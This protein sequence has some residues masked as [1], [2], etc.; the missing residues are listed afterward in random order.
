MSGPPLVV[1]PTNKTPGLFLRVNLLYGV[2]SPGSA[3][4]RCLIVGP[5]NSAG[6]AQTPDTEVRTIS[7]MA[8]IEAAAGVGSLPALAYKAALQRDPTIKCDLI[9]PTESNGGAATGTITPSGTISTDGTIR[10]VISGRVIDVPWLV[11][12]AADAW[13]TKAIAYINKRTAELFVTASSGGVGVVT[14]TAKGKGPAG[15]DVTLRAKIIEGCTSG[16]VAVSGAKLTGGTTEPVFTTALAT[17]AGTEYDYIAL[18]ASNA[19]VNAAS[20][21]NSDNLQTHIDAYNIG[22]DAHLQQGVLGTTTSVSSA[23]TGAIGLNSEVMETMLGIGVESLPCEVAGAEMGDRSYARKLRGNA[24]RIGT[25]MSNALLPSAD[26][27]GD[28][29]TAAEAIDALDNGVSLLH[30][31]ANGVIRVMR[32]ITTHSVDAN[33]NPD[34]R[35]LDCNEVDAMY[36]YAKDLRAALPQEFHQ[37][38]VAADREEGDEEL[39]EGVVECRDIKAF[40]ISRTMGYWVPKGYINGVEFQAAADAGQV[41]VQINATDETQVDIFIPA[42]PFKILSKMGVYVGKVG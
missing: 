30:Y 27:I 40:I 18:C 31:D 41:I 20:A 9:C 19:D 36:D 7:S 21:N 14:L 33:S 28:Q 23:K 25:D 38:K 8:D 32:A 4:L 6:G 42:K 11:G 29:P 34:Y 10:V 26:I 35:C 5:K 2:V 37:C 22:L 17:V 15:N 3:A 12:E 16:S 24:N 13:K 1:S 39:P